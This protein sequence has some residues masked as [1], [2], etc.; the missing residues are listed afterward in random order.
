MHLEK[1]SESSSGLAGGLSTSGAMMRTQTTRGVGAVD[2][3][4]G[5]HKRWRVI[6]P[7]GGAGSLM[8]WS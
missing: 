4:A 6:I 8:K 5:E 2:F 1:S 7:V 3:T